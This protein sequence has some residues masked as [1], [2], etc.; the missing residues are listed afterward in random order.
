[1]SAP[2]EA[3]FRDLLH[4]Y[5]TTLEPLA[6]NAVTKTE[7]QRQPQ[8]DGTTKIVIVPTIGDVYLPVDLARILAKS[9]AK[10]AFDQI[11]KY[12]KTPVVAKINELINEYNQ[13][14]S[15]FITGGGVTTAQSVEKIP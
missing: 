15:D 11:F 13:L 9:I 4:E 12:I 3:S 14:R 8:P 5:F 1:M 2:T 10:A 7:M 6:T